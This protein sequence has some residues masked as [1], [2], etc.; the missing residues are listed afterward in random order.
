MYSSIE[1][2]IS[3]AGIKELVHVQPFD[4]LDKGS[5]PESKYSL[6]VSL[7]YQSPDRTLTGDE[8]ES[9]D[10]KIVELLERRLGAQ[11]RK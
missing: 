8:V 3:D 1:E 4:R 9:F 11:L 6:S 7:I 5:F 2:V 10:R